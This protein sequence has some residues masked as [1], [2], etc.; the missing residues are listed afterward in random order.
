MDVDHLWLLAFMKDTRKGKDA[1]HLMSQFE[2]LVQHWATHCAAEEALMEKCEYKFREEHRKQHQEI[3]RLIFETKCEFDEPGAIAK[4]R[5]GNY[6]FR[7]ARV[8]D[9]LL[10][11]VDYADRQFAE[12]CHPTQLK[13][14][15]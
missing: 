12:H 10:S 5:S 2:K 7:I 6:D 13:E 3:M 1:E 14:S 15:K 9:R 8:Y 11:H 4:V